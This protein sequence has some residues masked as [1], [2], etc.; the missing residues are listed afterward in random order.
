MSWIGFF[1]ILAVAFG[2]YRLYHPGHRILRRRYSSKRLVW[3]RRHVFITGGSSGL[4]LALGQYA[5]SRGAH[6][7]LVARNE[8]RL[9]EAVESCQSVASFKNSIKSR[10]A[11]VSKVSEISE[12]MR[13][14]CAQYGPPAYVF[15]CAGFCVPG[16]FRDARMIDYET[17]MTTNYLGSV[18]TVR[19]A[20]EHVEDRV[21]CRVVAV[22]S[23]CALTTFAGFSAY[24]PSKAAVRSFWDTLRNEYCAQKHL[25]WHVFAP[26]TIDSPGL[27][28]EE[29]TKPAVT[30]TIEGKAHKFSPK[31]A[32]RHLIEGMERGEYMI[33]QE[34]MAFFLRMLSCSTV[35]RSRP[36]L[37]FV[38]YPWLPLFGAVVYRYYDWKV[39][40]AN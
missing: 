26:S 31:D 19:A 38:V 12:A 34:V 40:N 14:A 13:L 23:V 8:E 1:F 11:D 17:Q 2:M 5:A 21:P 25:Q 9:R 3:E 35:P 32:A 16:L 36:L 39:R 37:E 24:S 29:R 22:T 10:V 28:V 7:T 27:R 33:T 4:G 6:V 18:Y 20:L 15:C 30:K